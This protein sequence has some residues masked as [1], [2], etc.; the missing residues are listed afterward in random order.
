LNVTRF[1]YRRKRLA[2]PGINL[3]RVQ[4]SVHRTTE[5]AVSKPRTNHEQAMIVQ[6]D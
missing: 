3:A 4:L 1:E 5:Q 2:G 6:T